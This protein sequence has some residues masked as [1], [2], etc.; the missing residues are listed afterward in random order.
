MQCCCFASSV[1]QVHKWKYTT[2]VNWVKSMKTE[3]KFSKM[4]SI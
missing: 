3:L 4:F 1:E 2:G